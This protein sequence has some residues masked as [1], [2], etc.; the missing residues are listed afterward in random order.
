MACSS[1][2]ARLAAR[3]GAWE[4]QGDQFLHLWISWRNLGVE[5]L[6]LG[7]FISPV[8][9]QHTVPQPPN[10][11]LGKIGLHS[12]KPEKIQQHLLFTVFFWG[13]PCSFWTPSNWQ[14]MK[15]QKVLFQKM[16]IFNPRS[17]SVQSSPCHSREKIPPKMSWQ[18]TL[19]WTSSGK[20]GGALG[21][22]T[23]WMCR[24]CHWF[25]A[26]QASETGLTDFCSFLKRQKGPSRIN[27]MDGFTALI[28]LI[29]VTVQVENSYSIQ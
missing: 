13:V 5:S 28:L 16:G 29:T 12:S 22:C 26:F 25:T 7:T 17:T 14:P 21:W 8:L 18:T 27:G 20:R 1:P 11:D 19:R 2:N 6:T 15:T 23:W 24:K 4:H 9:M 10:V 3:P